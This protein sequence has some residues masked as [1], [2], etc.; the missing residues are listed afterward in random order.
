MMQE[1]PNTVLDDRSPTLFERIRCACGLMLGLRR[2]DL[3]A[4]RTFVSEIYA[5][6]P[7]L[8]RWAKFVCWSLG[9]MLSTIGWD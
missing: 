5:G 8:T 9:Q 3:R 2:H 7:F 1:N 6:Q 4:A